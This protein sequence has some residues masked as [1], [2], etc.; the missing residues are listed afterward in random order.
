VRNRQGS[1]HG[2]SRAAQRYG[3]GTHP[4]AGFI[5]IECDSRRTVFQKLRRNAARA[6]V[7]RAV[8]AFSGAASKLIEEAWSNANSAFPIATPW[9]GNRSSGH[10]RARENEEVRNERHERIPNDLGIRQ[11]R[12]ARQSTR[13]R[14]F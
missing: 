11:H 7:V 10:G 14:T 9:A 8:S 2:A 3:D 6:V 4:G 13:R 1:H 12:V 5:G